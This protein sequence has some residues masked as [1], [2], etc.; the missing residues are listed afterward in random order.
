[1]ALGVSQASSSV[2]RGCSSRSF[3]VRSLYLSKALLMI[4]WKL[5]TWFEDEEAVE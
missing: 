4:A 2:M 3:L 1:M 5:E